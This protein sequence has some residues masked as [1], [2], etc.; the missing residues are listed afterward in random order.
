ME[1]RASLPHRIAFVAMAVPLASLAV[2]C[3]GAGDGDTGVAPD[4]PDAS[5]TVAPDPGT[6][7]PG[8]TDPWNDPGEP[9]AP[10]E[11][12]ETR[13]SGCLDPDLGP[14]PDPGDPGPSDPGGAETVADGVDP[15]DA[16]SDPGPP[17]DAGCLS[18]EGC[19][20]I[21]GPAPPC[22]RAACGTDGR[23]SFVPGE[24]GI[25]CEDGDPCTLDDLCL[26]GTCEP[27]GA[28]L[29]CA[30]ADPCT[31]DRCVPGTGCTH[32]AA[33]D[34]TPCDDGNPCTTPDAC[35]S[36]ACL[37]GTNLCAC[38]ED[39]DCPD[40]GDLCNGSLFCD[41]S[42]VPY[43]C[44]VKPG[45]VIE[46]PDPPGECLAASCDPPTGACGEQPVAEGTPCDD[47][48]PCT[49]GDCCVEG[50]CLPVEDACQCRS[51]LDCVPYEDGD[52]CDGMLVCD[53]GHLPYSC[54]EDPTTA[55]VCRQPDD[56]CRVSTCVPATGDCA[57][58]AAPDGTPCDDHDPCTGDDRCLS[59]TCRPGPVPLCSCPSDMVPVE[60]RFCID[61]Y[62]ASRPDATASS[63]GVDSSIAVSRSG[64]LPWFPIASV[65]EAQ[66]ACTAAGKRLCLVTEI[67][68]AC[69][70]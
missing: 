36:G 42:V 13:E 53:T 46:C 41:R 68:Q 52:R 62:E 6:T 40:D 47:S 30:D 20:Q 39:G 31:D 43:A 23:C 19:A 50:A 4:L 64:A 38:Q 70:G 9:D 61:R 2:A 44:V 14:L 18:D 66:L 15:G 45:T 69:Q 57:E 17:P 63:R 25:P 55:I 28:M 11:G 34:G 7:D 29:D 21:L 51:D 5:E 3:G 65:T 32:T 8:T 22:Q 58:A 24:N 56:P 33:Q 27:V 54:V 35:V 37:P 59:G 49:I 60:D 48:D 10:E 67:L 1:G 12:D 26:A 16:A